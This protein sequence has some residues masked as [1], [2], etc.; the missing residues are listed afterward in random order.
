MRDVDFYYEDCRSV[1]I[2]PCEPV[3]DEDLPPPPPTTEP[4]SDSPTPDSDI[5]NGNKEL[6]VD[7]SQPVS[8]DNSGL[9][10]SASSAENQNQQAGGGLHI[11]IN[12]RFEM[13]PAF[14]FP[15]DEAPPSDLISGSEYPLLPRDVTDNAAM[16]PMVNQIYKEF[17][18]LGFEEKNNIFSR[19]PDSQGN[20]LVRQKY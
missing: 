8:L 5:L 14:H 9:K 18:E 11:A 16:F 17:Q 10:V 3:D 20:Y 12:R 4:P 6:C 2:I 19:S 1:G 7:V 15:E 13:P